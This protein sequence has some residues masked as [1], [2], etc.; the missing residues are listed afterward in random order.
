MG[1]LTKAQQ[2]LLRIM[3]FSDTRFISRA[4]CIA[5]GALADF[6]R[7]RRAGLI[8]S[9]KYETSVEGDDFLNAFDAAPPTPAGA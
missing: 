2:S 3:E 8:Q 7:A 1:K 4:E 9:A 6:N 5:H